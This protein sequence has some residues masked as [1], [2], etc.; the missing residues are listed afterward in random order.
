MATIVLRSV[1]GSPLT[2]EEAD[3][4]F[5][6]I[7]TEVGTKLDTS[8]FTAS[9]ILTKLSDDDDGTGKNL[10]ATTLGG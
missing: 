1:K 7:N 3:A 10:N 9:A 4:N 8:A 6:N 2:I 5:T